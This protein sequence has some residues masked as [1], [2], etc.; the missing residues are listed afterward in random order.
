[1]SKVAG[2]LQEHLIGEVTA[3]ADVRE[4][5]ST[6]SSV[7]KITPQV[8]VY[9]RAE[10]DVRKTARFAWQ[11][12]ER[13]RSIPITARG[14]GTDQGGAAI[15]D[16]IIM[17]FPAHMNKILTLD[18]SK[19][20]LTVQPGLNYGKL[21][22]TLQTHGLFLPPFPASLEYSTIVGAVA[23]NAA[24]EKSIKYGVTKDYV[25]SLRVVLANGEVIKTGRITKRELNHKMGLATF[26]GEVYRAMDALL[27]DNKDL[28]STNGLNV[29]KNTAG[30]NI[31]D[32]KNKDGSVDL[33]P[34]FVGSQGTLGI[35]TEATLEAESYNPKTTLFAAFFDDILKAGHVVLKLRELLPSSLEMVDSHLLNFLDQHNPSQLKGIVSKPFPK[36]ILLIEFDDVTKRSQ[37]KKAKNTAKLLKNFATE[38]KVTSNLHEQEDLWKI[39]YGAATVTWQNIGTKKALPIIEDGIVPVE[40]LADYI[41]NIY[42]LFENYGLEVA[43]W[44][45]AGAANLHIQPFLDLAQVGDRQ[46]VFKLMDSYYQMVIAMGGS[47]SGEHNDGRLRAPYLPSVYGPKIYELFQKVKQIFDPYDILNPGVKIDVETKDLQNIMR[48]EYS[49]SH[50]YDHMPRI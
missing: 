45:H 13:G 37:Q 18:S 12:A 41:N 32:I 7:F 36:V 33:T 43:I 3:S 30:Y 46:R 28:L 4:H 40:K 26:E 50:L 20:S 44:G 48:H 39:R 16:G 27:K 35:I 25:K 29:A 1:M 9:P 15:G 14:L 11:L 24:G 17:A 38:F 21:Q 34:L 49:V 2:Y 22:Q 19:S 10:S 8:I 23:N 5:F 6:D 47:T 31:W 42:K